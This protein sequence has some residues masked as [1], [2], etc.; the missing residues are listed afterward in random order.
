VA[1]TPDTS[2]G[3]ADW[4]AVDGGCGRRAVNDALAALQTTALA[5]LRRAVTSGRPI[6][7]R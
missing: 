5:E 2:T 7:D 6:A 1:M 3:A 4:T